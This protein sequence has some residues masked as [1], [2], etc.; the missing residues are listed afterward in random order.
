MAELSALGM[1]TRAIASVVGANFATVSRG[2]VPT[3]VADATPVEPAA[4]SAPTPEEVTA[5]TVP[6]ADAP[7]DGSDWPRTA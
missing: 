6:V 4:P 2:L 1:P 7:W 3:G 5:M